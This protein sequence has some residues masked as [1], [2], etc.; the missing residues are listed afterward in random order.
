[1][2]LMGLMGAIAVRTQIVQARGVPLTPSGSLYRAQ[3]GVK[4]LSTATPALFLQGPG[5]KSEA[6]KAF[7]ATICCSLSEVA[8]YQLCPF[9]HRSQEAAQSPASR[10]E[11]FIKPSQ[12]KDALECQV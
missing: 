5:L 3:A 1:M 11:A 6:S 7:T 12:P 9:Y 10:T 2:Q 8:T 4:L